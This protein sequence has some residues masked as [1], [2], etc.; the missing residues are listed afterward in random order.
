MGVPPKSAERSRSRSVARD[1]EGRVC[2]HLLLAPMENLGCGKL[3]TRVRNIKRR[4]RAI[5]Y[6]R[7]S[8]Y[9]LSH[10]RTVTSISRRASTTPG[11]SRGDAKRS[12]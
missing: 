3:V 1:G 2:A 10:S 8:S 4:T 12:S 6:S 7:A 9:S 5:L 11:A